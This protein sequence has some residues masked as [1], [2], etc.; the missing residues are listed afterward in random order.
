MFAS[1]I[2]TAKEREIRLNKSYDRFVPHEFLNILEKDSIT[3]VQL[4][5]QVEKEMTVLFSDIRGFTSISENM[6]PKAS[7]MPA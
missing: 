7:S 3:E 6:T 4:G 1:G 5:D 2:Y